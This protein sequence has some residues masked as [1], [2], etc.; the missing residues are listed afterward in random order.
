MEKKEI[1]RDK[2][3]RLSLYKKNLREKATKAELAFAQKLDENNIKYTF[4]KIYYNLKLS[5]IL[6]FYIKINNKKLA[7]E[8]DGDYHIN[9]FQK[10]KDAYRDEWLLLNR[11]C[12]TIRFTNKMI[13]TDIEICIN[14][15]KQY[16]KL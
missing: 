2:N 5:V 3:K 15:V 8:I 9:S 14:K 1:Y 6:D 13:E 7:V 11:K 12:P 10:Q 16:F 4:Q